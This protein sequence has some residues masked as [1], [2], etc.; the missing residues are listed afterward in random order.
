MTL[1]AWPA[2]GCGCCHRRQAQ[3]AYDTAAAAAGDSSE[4]AQQRASEAREALR[5]AA[6]R[7]SSW[8]QA[9]AREAAGKAPQ[10]PAPRSTA[11][12][13]S[14]AVTDTIDRWASCMERLAGANTGAAT[15]CDDFVKYMLSDMAG[16]QTRSAHTRLGSHLSDAA[17]ACL[18]PGRPAAGIWPSK[19]HRCLLCLLL[20]TCRD[21]AEGH[22]HAAAEEP[23]CS[24][25]TAQLQE[26]HCCA[27]TVTD[28]CTRL[29][30]A[31]TRLIGG[32]SRCLSVRYDDHRL[33]P[34]GPGLCGGEL[35]G[36]VGRPADRVPAAGR[37]GQGRQ[38]AAGAG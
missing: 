38:E 12:K 19:Q 14:Q 29:P 28:T 32:L 13:A 9:S 1:T 2:S 11:D 17:G 15:D 37:C 21:G 7:A 36:H 34:Q 35:R 27:L 25:N 3:Q 33:C 6:E 18:H 31:A 23:E 16:K 26:H 4:A 20:S 22:N 10:P 5:A 8:L 24:S 30:P